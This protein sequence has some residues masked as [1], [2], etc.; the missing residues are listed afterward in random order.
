MRYHVAFAFYSVNSTIGRFFKSTIYVRII[1]NIHRIF[2]D[3]IF[4]VN[5]KVLRTVKINID[6]EYRIIT[7]VMNFVR[8]G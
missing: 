3:F 7:R 8:F 1:Q 4:L 5:V 2:E 6:Y